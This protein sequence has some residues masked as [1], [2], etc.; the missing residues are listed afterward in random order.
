MVMLPSFVLRPLSWLAAA[1]LLVMLLLVAGDA[2][3]SHFRAGTIRWKRPDPAQPLTV[4]FT[5]ITSWRDDFSNPTTT[6]DFG[7][8]SDHGGASGVVVGSGADANNNGYEVREYSALH[9]YAAAGS[10]I[11]SFDACCRVDGLVNGGGGGTP[12][13]D[14]RVEAHIDLADASNS[15][16]PATASTAVIQ[17]QAGALR[18]YAF[19]LFDPDGDPISCRLASAAESGLTPPATAV[20]QVPANLAQPTVAISAAGTECVLSWDLSAAVAGEQYA[21]PLVMESTRAG[22]ISSTALDIIVEVVSPPPPQCSGSG[23]FVAPPGALFMA[24]INATDTAANVTVLNR[25]TINLPAAATLAPVADSH[26]PPFATT[27]SWTPTM[28]DVGTRVVLVS[29]TND[30]HLSGTCALSIYVPPCP[31]YGQACVVGVGACEA[32]GTIVCSGSSDQCNA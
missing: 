15:A 28:A 17:L 14:Y 27:L 6:L 30:N 25:T 24:A 5:V 23:Q 2:T 1:C 26:A 10:Y 13:T 31:G 11:A 12:S 21:V 32:S 18:T 8:G 9:S 7:D 16:G 3:A 20:P 19:P 29:F 22:A 4:E